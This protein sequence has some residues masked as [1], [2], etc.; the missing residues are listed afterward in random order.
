MKRH[1]VSDVLM[2]EY[3]GGMDRMKACEAVYARDGIDEDPKTLYDNCSR[4]AFAMT[5]EDKEMELEVY[6]SI[7]ELN[8][9]EEWREFILNQ[10][11]R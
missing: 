11:I 1:R 5:N 4:E 9:P 8:E 10:V 2:L 7:P 3:L 6:R